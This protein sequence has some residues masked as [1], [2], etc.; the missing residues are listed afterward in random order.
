MFYLSSVGVVVCCSLLA[1]L[2]FLLFVYLVSGLSLW[3]GLVFVLLVVFVV[4]LLWCSTFNSVVILLICRYKDIYLICLLFY[5]GLVV[6]VCLRDWLA[7]S[8]W[9]YF[10]VWCLH[11]RVGVAWWFVMGVV[12][13][14]FCC[15]LLGHCLHSFVCYLLSSVCLLWCFD[16]LVCFGGLCLVYFGVCCVL[17]LFWSCLLVMLCLQCWFCFVGVSGC[18]CVLDVWCCVLFGFALFACLIVDWFV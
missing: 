1:V 14:V 11:V 9:L 6:I 5:V 4:L 3:L 2:W 10:I 13:V 15:S 12:R 7:V 17:I 8:F 18:L 16:C